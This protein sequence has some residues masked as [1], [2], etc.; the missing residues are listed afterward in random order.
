MTGVSENLFAIRNLFF[1][2]FF[3]DPKIL[4]KFIDVYILRIITL[5]LVFG[6]SHNQL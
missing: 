6:G 4:H 1:I 3:Y 2:N 5:L